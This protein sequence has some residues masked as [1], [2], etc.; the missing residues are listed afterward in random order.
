MLGISPLVQVYIIGQTILHSQQSPS[1]SYQLAWIN[2]TTL[3]E[4]YNNGTPLNMTGA[5]MEPHSLSYGAFVIHDDHTV[6][7]VRVSNA[8]TVS[9][10]T[11][12]KSWD[13]RKADI[14]FKSCAVTHAA[15]HGGRGGGGLGWGWEWLGVRV[16]GVGAG[17][18]V[19]VA[20]SYRSGMQ[21]QS[22]FLN[23]TNCQGY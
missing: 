22:Q 2:M 9:G 19:A 5:A 3:L 13:A 17:F 4:T 14:T 1:E 15:V 7:A 23:A 12:S 16:M 8:I 21:S 11:P 20:R 6:N 10:I 18:G